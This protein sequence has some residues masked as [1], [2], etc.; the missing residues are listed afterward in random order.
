MRLLNNTTRW[1]VVVLASAL[2]LG[3]DVFDGDDDD[4]EPFDGGSSGDGDVALLPS[5]A[6]ELVSSGDD[7]ITVV[8]PLGEDGAD[9]T[10]ILFH[11]DENP[12]MFGMFDLEDGTMTVREGSGLVVNGTAQ[13]P[14]LFRG[15]SFEVTGDWVIPIDGPPT[16]GSMVVN[17]PFELVYVDVTADGLLQL[18]WDPVPDGVIDEEVFLSF[19]ELDDFLDSDAPE[20]QKLGVVAVEIGGNFVVDLMAY[21]VAGFE[22]IVDELADVSPVTVSCDAFSDLGLAVPAPPPDIPDQG[23]MTL[24]WLDDSNDGNVGPGDSFD[25]D[26]T[27]CLMIVEPL[28]D[29]QIALNGNYSL[30]SYTEVVEND[31][32]VR[33]GYEGESPA[34]RPG[35]VV[36]DDLQQ[37][38]VYD[39]DGTGGSNVATVHLGATINGRMTLVF[40]EPAD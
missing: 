39:A 18:G 10:L 14:N 4:D 25:T 16:Q 17:R 8:A 34:G 7:P 6:Y 38:E 23:L 1:L 29:D 37:F 19:D 2:A 31:V 36:F 22:A 11:E 3:C 15:F 28:D 33:I 21:G 40:T 5:Y 30:N 24:T 20:W 26:L 32:V 35:G 9:V 12:G 13:N 27:Y